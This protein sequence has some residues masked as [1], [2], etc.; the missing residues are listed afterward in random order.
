MRVA[1]QTPRNLHA[2]TKGT[3]STHNDQTIHLWRRSM[4]AQEAIKAEK[5]TLCFVAAGGFA[6]ANTNR[7]TIS[8]GRPHRKARRASLP[9]ARAAMSPTTRYSILAGRY[10]SQTS[11]VCAPR[12]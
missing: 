1:T 4:D 3:V 10:S 7:C 8:H 9:P 6:Y 2:L 11:F 5:D 12:C